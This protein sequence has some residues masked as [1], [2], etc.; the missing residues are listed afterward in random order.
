M[1]CKG[2]KSLEFIYPNCDY[3]TITKSDNCGVF[4]EIL[5]IEY[6]VIPELCPCKMCIIKSMCNVGCNE[7]RDFKAPHLRMPVNG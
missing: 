6:I 3:K 1:D 7:F 5:N 2:C 4:H